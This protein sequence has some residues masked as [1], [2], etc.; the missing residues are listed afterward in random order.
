MYDSKLDGFILA[1]ELG[2][3]SKAAKRLFISPNAVIK[4]VNQLEA[5]V[6]VTLMRRS[7]HGVILTPSG[8]AYLRGAKQVVELAHDTIRRARD[9]AGAVTCDVRVATSPM[10]PVGRLQR[11]WD[12]LSCRHPALSLLVVQI[13]DDI[14]SWPK[15]FENLGDAVD[16]AVTITPGPVWHWRDSCGFREIYRMP[17]CAMVPRRH[18]LAGMDTIS[19]DDLRGERL[20]LAPRGASPDFDRVRGY[21][22]DSCPSITIVEGDPYD[23]PSLNRRVIA[24]EFFLGEPEWDGIHP[25]VHAVPIDWQFDVGLSLVYQRSP[26]GYVR[27]FVD[28][29]DELEQ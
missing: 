25:S 4:Q 6:G 20:Y 3:F 12:R 1:A 7:A 21:L 22:A 16:T 27:E 5:E 19:V 9:I 11:L 24:N 15:V 26:S 2:S 18:H 13:S 23:L 29:F 10:R 8:E 14:S 28:S 17:I